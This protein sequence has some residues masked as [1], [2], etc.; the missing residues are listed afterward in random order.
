MPD[1]QEFEQT[2]TEVERSLHDLKERY[3]QVQRDQQRK[4]TVEAEIDRMTEQYHRTRSKPML[5]ELKQLQTQ[6]EELELA[7]ESKLFD[8]QG[9]REVFWQAVRFVGIGIIIGWLLKSWVG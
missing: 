2:L 1:G 3:A 8:W 9:L 6:L 5:T 4:E 7:L